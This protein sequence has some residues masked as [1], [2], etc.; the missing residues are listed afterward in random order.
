MEFFEDF[1][2][3]KPHGNTADDYFFMKTLGG[4]KRFYS[5]NSGQCIPKKQ[6]NS[7]FISDIKEKSKYE[8]YMVFMEERLKNKNNI[9]TMKE[10][11]LRSEERIKELDCILTEDYIEK[12]KIYE[13]EE[14]NRKEKYEKEQRQKFDDSFSKYTI[15][16]N[17][18]N[19]KISLL[20]KYKITSK[21]EWFSWLLQNHP[22]KGGDGE[23]CAAVIAEG[24][25]KGW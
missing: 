20:V 24:K 18:S 15:K 2:N 12:A 5:K 1:I 22:D 19:P 6:I 17:V 10:R 21:K 8:D 9:E 13:Q 25:N 4:T 14:K 3:G 7:C 16:N 11:I 23:I